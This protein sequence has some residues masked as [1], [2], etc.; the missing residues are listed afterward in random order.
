MCNHFVRVIKNETLL[1]ILLR[2][3]EKNMR[4][5]DHSFF[6]EFFKTSF[7]KVF[8]FIVIIEVRVIFRYSNTIKYFPSLPTS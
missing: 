2:I 7:V 8:Y 1:N 3:T 4:L 5:P 6:Y